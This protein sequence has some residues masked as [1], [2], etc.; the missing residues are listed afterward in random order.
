MNHPAMMSAF[1]TEVEKDGST[2]IVK[3]KLVDV[4]GEERKI[5]KTGAACYYLGA[6]M[7][8]AKNA[9]HIKFDEKDSESVKHDGSGPTEVNVYVNLPL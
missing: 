6:L 3:V 8:A 7:T 1:E 5:I 4:N 9:G 2:L